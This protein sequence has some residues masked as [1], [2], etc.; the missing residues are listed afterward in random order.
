MPRQKI[1]EQYILDLIEKAKE[2]FYA[3]PLFGEKIKN[4]LREIR[5]CIILNSEMKE[6]WY[7]TAGI[8]HSKSWEVVEYNLK[9]KMD[10][11]MVE[12]R[13]SWYV[14]ELNSKLLKKSDKGSVYDT[15]SHELAHLLEMRLNGRYN[16][17]DRR[18]HNA[19]WKKIH[20]AMGGSGMAT[21]KGYEEWL[22]KNKSDNS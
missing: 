9:E 13:M 15:V 19:C 12:G 11:V 7:A 2:K 18:Y 16:R 3:S 5:P 22:S 4:I 17:Q 8:E 21:D 6:E 10:Y 14:I 20:R 1:T